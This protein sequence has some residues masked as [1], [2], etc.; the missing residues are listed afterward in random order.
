MAHPA[1]PEDPAT[2][3]RRRAGTGTTRR[4]VQ[5]AWPA[6]AANL[7]QSVVGIASVGIVGH[8]LGA[9]AVAATGIGQRMFFFQQVVIMAVTAGT[10]ALVARAWGAKDRAEAERVTRT[11][12]WLCL[13]VSATLT[14]PAVLGARLLAGLFDLDPATT[15]LTATF[16]R[17]MSL[18]AVPMAVMFVI[19]SALRAAGDTLTPLWIGAAT[20]AIQLG[21]LYGFVEGAFGMPRLGVMGVALAT[22]IGLTFGALLSLALWLRGRLVLGFGPPGGEWDRLRVRRLVRIGTPAGLEQAA[23]QTGFTAFIWIVALYGNEANAAYQIGV[24]ILSL[25]FLVGLG[26]SIAAS[27]L[28]GQHLGAEDPDGAALA[29]W[30][31]MTL[32]IVVMVVFGTII[33]AFAEPIARLLIDDPEVIRL[34]TVF[35][36]VLGSVQALMAIE[37]TLGGAL[38]GAGDTRFPLFVVLTGMVA[39]RL[40]SAGVVTLLGW[41]VEWIYASLLADYVVKA[42]ML[43]ARF[44]GGRWKTAIAPSR[45]MPA[46]T[47]GGAPVGRAPAAEPE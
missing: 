24:Q 39:V 30:R 20:L 14:A 40:T 2:P 23:F 22:G 38:R 5:L 43:V 25:S 11:S 18:S 19:G 21:G 28:V 45:V 35:I 13:A 8:T 33:I 26:F 46:P 29:G 12:L 1:S 6:V 16:I 15:E 42:V 34:T 9:P 10:T 3:R 27:T 17:W 47:P 36:Y 44:R 41:P 7:L 37:F 32:A 4:I 31:A